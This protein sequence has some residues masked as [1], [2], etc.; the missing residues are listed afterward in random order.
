MKLIGAT[1]CLTA[2]FAVG[3]GAQSGTT[4]VTTETGRDK[5]TVERKIEIK[6]GKDIKMQGCL[7]RNPG[8]GYMLTSATSGGMLYA[9][10]TDE[11][12]SKYV[13]HRVEV[14]GKAAD[15][16][17]GKVKIESKVKSENEAVGTSGTV[18]AEATAT[19]EVKGALGIPYLGVKSVTIVPGGCR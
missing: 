4:K 16:G 17:K 13:G 5:T 15:L 18:E 2:A 14:A 7:A 8:G 9:L 1:C 19:S 3:V 11:N 10:V 6:D 12:L